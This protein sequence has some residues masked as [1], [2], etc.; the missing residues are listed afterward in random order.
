[1]LI[2]EAIILSQLWGHYW[3]CYIAT[4]QYRQM[5]QIPHQN[6]ASVKISQY[7]KNVPDCNKLFDTEVAVQNMTSN[8]EDWLNA[9]LEWD[10]E[11]EIFAN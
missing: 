6:F 9:F 3:K 5:P 8:D 10:N 4:I 1:M 11:T 7:S 2:Y